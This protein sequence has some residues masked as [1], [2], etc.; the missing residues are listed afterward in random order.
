MKPDKAVIYFTVCSGTGYGMIISLLSLYIYDYIYLDFRIKL[1]L[2]FLSFF[3]ILSGLI[4]STIHLGHPERAWRA[5]SQWKSS[6]LS[7]EGIA[8]VITFIP[9][10]IFYFL[11]ILNNKMELIFSLLI[12]T[13]IFAIITIYCTAKIYSSLKSIPAW[14]NSL[15]PIIYILNS[16]TLGSLIT[17][18]IAFNFGIKI[19]LLSNFIISLSLTT[20]FLKLLYWYLIKIKSKSN[21]ETAT[22][23]HNNKNINFFEGPHTGKNFLT[24]EMINTIKIINSHK[25]RFLVCIFTYI[26]PLYFIIQEPYLITN[27]FLSSIT[28][29]IVCIFAVI[30]MFVERYLFFIE[31]KHTVSLYYGNKFI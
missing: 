8:A 31:A 13:S 14:N 7:R 27:Y 3:L 26:S 6:W 25:L 10:T 2:S 22:G 11:W 16:L 1:F 19:N 23:L 15:V 30:G 4:A 9:L 17:Y 5:L 28:L 24:S 21:I 20:L 29:V 18:V 12:L